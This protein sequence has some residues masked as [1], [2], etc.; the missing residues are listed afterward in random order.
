MDSTQFDNNDKTRQ[1][2]K[3]LH[4]EEKHGFK[5]N[6]RLTQIHIELVVTIVFFEGGGGWGRSAIYVKAA[7]VE[8][9]Y[10]QTFWQ[11]LCNN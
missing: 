1:G 8:N 9:T 2:Q 7:L 4:L 6:F 5:Q 11:N 10:I 3:G